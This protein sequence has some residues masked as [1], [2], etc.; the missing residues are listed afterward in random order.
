MAEKKFKFS[1]IV[2]LGI[3]SIM[4][5]GIFL[6]PSKAYMALGPYGSLIVLLICAIVAT[7]MALTFAEM[8][9]MFSETGGPYIYVRET[10]GKFW[11][12]QVGFVRFI[13]TCMAWGTNMIAVPT[14]LSV[15]D[16][17]FASDAGKLIISILLI[18]L[19]TIINLRGV[20]SSE[21][22]NN[23]LTFIKFIPLV[24]FIITGI[25]FVKLSNFEVPPTDM[26]PPFGLASIGAGF[27]LLIYSFYGF[28]NIGVAAQDMEN[29]TKNVPRAIFAVMMI[30]TIAYFLIYFNAIGIL[31]QDMYYSGAPV[32][33][34]MGS[35]MGAWAVDAIVGVSVISMIGF[36]LATAF[37]AARNIVPLSKDH[38]MP[39][40]AG[41]N[42]AK[43]VP[44]VSI[45]TVMLITI[46]IVIVAV[47]T[48]ENTFVY[49]VAV[50]GIGRFLQYIPVNIAVLKARK[51]GI[52]GSYK[53][54]MA[55]LLVS[56]AVI[57]SIICIAYSVMGNMSVLTI[58]ILPL[59]LVS[60][61][62]W[63]VYSS[64]RAAKF[65]K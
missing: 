16:P 63:F 4:G 34:A 61:L 65:K 29:P 44:A 53:L 27:L 28:E 33:D 30:L 7:I 32:G 40:V 37:A 38:F 57:V 39:E 58:G 47:F 22:F 54:P 55:G 51:L 31:G 18:I 64:P 45:I 59:I 49:L 13:V 56:I 62:T 43:G 2:F 23:I 25:F 10:Y 48:S 60:L 3:N 19:I 11:G 41:E 15:V 21:I 50:S 35:Y 36:S 26:V 17:W 46:F 42:N 8:S 20:K 1:S 5:A 9:G 14:A 12:F 24:I 6:T 52:K